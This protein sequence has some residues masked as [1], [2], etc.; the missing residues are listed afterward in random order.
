M[1]NVLLFLLYL[2]YLKSKRLEWA[3]LIWR[4]GGM[5]NKMFIGRLKGKCLGVVRGKDG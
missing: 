4:S 2:M 5:V 3:G 1:I